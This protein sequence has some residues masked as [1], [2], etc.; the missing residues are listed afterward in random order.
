MK[1]EVVDAVVRP[2][3]RIGRC[4]GH[5]DVHRPGYDDTSLH[6]V[7][8]EERVENGARFR[9][10]RWDA[11]R[12]P[13]APEA[14]APGRRTGPPSLPGFRSRNAWS[15]TGRKEASGVD[16]GPRVHDVPRDVMAMAVQCADAVEQRAAVVVIA[17]L[18]R[19]DRNPLLASGFEDR[20]RQ[21]GMRT[22]LD[23][24]GVS[25]LQHPADRRFEEHGGARVLPPVG[26]AGLVS[27][28]LFTGDRR[29]QRKRGS[30]RRQT[31][32]GAEEVVLHARPC[33]GCDRAPSRRDTG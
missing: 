14:D 2:V 32:E 24:V 31:L 25:V 15:A 22:Q 6:P 26:G 11:R 4:Q 10:P 19:H 18:G 23:E 29:I 5:F 20:C 8:G 7:I 27:V 28:Q 1:H 16:P 30:F 17:A 3:G 12:S 21:H 9:L 13:I 33:S